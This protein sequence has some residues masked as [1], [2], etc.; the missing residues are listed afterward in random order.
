MPYVLNSRCAPL[1]NLQLPPTV[2]LMLML[3]T[4]STAVGKDGFN[5]QA[6]PALPAPG[7]LACHQDLSKCSASPGDNLLVSASHALAFILGKYCLLLLA[8]EQNLFARL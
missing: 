4:K 3:V 2:P 7:Q 8:S 6:L 1:V 5:S